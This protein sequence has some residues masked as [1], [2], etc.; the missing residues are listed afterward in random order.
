MLEAPDIQE[1]VHSE[2][3]G[4]ENQ[5]QDN[6]RNAD[7]GCFE[8]SDF[9]ELKNF[10]KEDAGHKSNHRSELFIDAFREIKQP[11]QLSVVRFRFWLLAWCVFFRRSFVWCGICNGFSSRRWCV[12]RLG[13]VESVPAASVSFELDFCGRGHF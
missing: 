10:D 11:L 5:D 1:T 9:L 13:A 6:E 2:E 8:F 7:A 12:I 3:E 4:T